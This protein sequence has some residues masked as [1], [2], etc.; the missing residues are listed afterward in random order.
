MAKKRKP[1]GGGPPTPIIPFKQLGKENKRRLAQVKAKRK[2]RTAG[3][4]GG[5]LDDV[6]RRLKLYLQEAENRSDITGAKWSLVTA[7]PKRFW[8]RRF[9]LT[10]KPRSFFDVVEEG[11]IGLSGDRVIDIIMAKRQCSIRLRVRD[12]QAR[13]TIVLSTPV[14]DY[15]RVIN[16]ILDKLRQWA[17]NYGPTDDEDDEAWRVLE[18]T[19]FST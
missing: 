1:P 5:S 7:K 18:V 15:E 16:D 3:L 10:P 9:T 19:F 6:G 2:K 12:P 4:R 14:G 11:F 17:S 8:A 13:R